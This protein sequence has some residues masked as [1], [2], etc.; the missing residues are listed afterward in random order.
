MFNRFRSLFYIILIL[1][2]C[3]MV[4]AGC[5]DNNKLSS[6]DNKIKIAVIVKKKDT[7]FY[8]VVRMGA[9]AASKEFDVDINFD[10]PISEKDIEGQ[11]KL[12]E[13]SINNKY[14]AIVLAAGDYNKLSGVVDKAA[15]VNIPVIIID[16]QLNSDQIKAF[17]GTDNMD[18]GIKLGQTLINRVGPTCNIAVMNFIKGAASSDLREQGVFSTIKKYPKVQVAAN[19]YCNSDENVA[20]QQIK[21]TIE[22]NPGLDAVVCTN[23]QGTVG[24][25]R[26]VED[27]NMAGKIKIIGL[28]STPEEVSF[29]EKGVVEALIIQNPFNMGYLGVKYAV[30]SIYN[31]SLPKSTNTGLT[32]IDKQN[33]YL[34]ENEKLVFPFSE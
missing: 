6:Q 14:N 9:E 30:D 2:F 4:I 10:G 32:I 15:S 19:L 16:S 8:S 7:S 1:I 29:V 21:K 23:A 5:D 26:A 20:Y 25:A 17:V 12:V 22:E 31:K 33:M 28:D 3:C 11:I 13:Y 27:K 24:A 34:P 18:A